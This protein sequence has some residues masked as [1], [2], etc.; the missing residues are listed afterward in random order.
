VFANGLAFASSVLAMNTYLPIAELQICGGAQANPDN[1]VWVNDPTYWSTASAG[2]D[3]RPSQLNLVGL[4][5]LQAR[6]A[7][8]YI[9]SFAQAELAMMRTTETDKFAYYPIP[10]L[11]ET[12]QQTAQQALSTS[13]NL[14]GSLTLKKD[15]TIIRNQA[16]VN[17]LAATAVGTVQWRRSTI[18][19]DFTVN[20]IPPGVTTITYL[21]DVPTLWVETAYDPFDTPTGAAVETRNF[22]CLNTATDGSGTYVSSS[23]QV[24]VR[25]SAFTPSSVTVEYTN[26]T[27]TTYYTVNNT[28]NPYVHILGLA[29]ITGETSHISQSATSI[30]TRGVRGLTLDAPAIQDETTAT[31]VANELVAR[32][33]RP[34]VSVTGTV[35]GDPRRQPGD[36]VTLADPTGTKATGNWRLATIDHNVQGADYT[37]DITATLAL[38]VGVWGQSTWGDCLWGP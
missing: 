9:S 7:W 8:E 14:D 1:Y 24:R 12:A 34:R 13:T 16:T 36:M 38:S 22:V 19:D 21:T 3:I 4:S 26:L 15:P 25:V 11:A 30:A 35:R 18:H 2:A 37:Q 33:M 27:G 10:W 28:T 17:Y 29:L 20:T 32:L 5:E 31:W 23:S 6:E